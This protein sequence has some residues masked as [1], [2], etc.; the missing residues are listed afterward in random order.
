MW[1]L[2]STTKGDLQGIADHF[3]TPLKIA[4]AGGSG[5]GDSSSI[6]QGGGQDLTRSVGQVKRGEVDSGVRKALSLQAARGEILRQE[7]AL[8]EELK[9]KVE[10][11]IAANPRTS[12]MRRQMRLDL[13]P[14]GL[15]IQIVDDQSRAMFDS[16]SAVV[17]EHMRDLLRQI[18]A[19]LNEVPNR[20]SLS[21][22]TDSAPFGAGER[23]YSNWE[24]SADR[25]NASRRELVAGGMDDGKIVRVVGVASA[26][27][28]DA[29]DPR[30]PVNRR[31]SIVVMNRVAE[32]RLLNGAELA[33]DPP[34]QGSP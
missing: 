12:A 5:S 1:L 14:E 33:E 11:A 2:G 18:G 31:I 4:L 24:L 9:A 29:A 6:V 23:G 22:H 27:P 10:A 17:R 15:R 8:L 7:R 28:L 34:E 16:G 20:V 13:T 32:S 19:V 25:A 30:H 3:S 21:G 26:V